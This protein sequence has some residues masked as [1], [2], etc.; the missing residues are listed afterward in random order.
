MTTTAAPAA[1][2]TCR[3]CG[4][5]HP[6][7]DGD[8]TVLCACGTGRPH[9]A[10]PVEQAEAEQRYDGLCTALA[11]APVP[12]AHEHWI[13][14]TRIGP[15][16]GDALVLP[17]AAAVAEWL[18][19]EQRANRPIADGELTIAAPDGTRTNALA[20]LAAYRGQRA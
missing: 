13:E 4:H 20:W 8:T 1:T 15:G 17:D 19:N 14:N 9:L 11:A 2:Y 5:R 3:H 12:P 7:A 6:K 16:R 10:C 18:D